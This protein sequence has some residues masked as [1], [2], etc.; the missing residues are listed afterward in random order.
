MKIF[1]PGATHPTS[2]KTNCA[3][4]RSPDLARGAVTVSVAGFSSLPV[5]A[6]RGMRI[7]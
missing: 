7:Y 5:G 1:L 4:R 6:H 3:G 2:P